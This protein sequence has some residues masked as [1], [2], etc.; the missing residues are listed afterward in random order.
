MANNRSKAETVKKVLE[1]YNEGCNRHEIAEGAGIS[2]SYVYIIL[3][4]HGLEM[5]DKIPVSQDYRN[6]FAIKWNKSRHRVLRNAK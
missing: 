3:K 2:L 6:S 1:L 5:D 4:D